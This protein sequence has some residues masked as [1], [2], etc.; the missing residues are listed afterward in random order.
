M[1]TMKAAAQAFDATCARWRD[2]YQAALRQADLQNQ[3]IRDA[4]RSAGDKRQAER[5]RREAEAQLKLLT[6]VD[7]FAQSD[8]YSYRYF[9]TEGFLPGYSFPRLPISAFIPGRRNRQRDEFL[10]RPRFLAVTEFGPRAII[11]H[12]GS[13]YLINQII[14]PVSMSEEDEPLTTQVKQC[15]HCGYLHPVGNGRDYDV[16]ERCG[17]PLEAPLEALLRLQNVVTQ[18]RDRINSDEE[19]RQR[20]GYDIRTGVRFTEKEGHALVQSAVVRAVYQD[21]PLALLTYAPTATLWRINLGW[22][23][24]K[25]KNRHGFVL[26]IERGYW[27]RNEQVEDDPVDPLSER[28]KLV[29]PF[30]EDSRNCL[31]FEPLIPLSIEQMTSLQAALKRAIEVRYQLEDNELAVEPL[32]DSFNRRLL[33]FYEAAEGGAGVLRRLVDE[34]EALACDR[35]GC[36]GSLPF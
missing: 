19:E 12:E 32:P 3:I 26:D 28:T 20:L 15:G 22:A 21:T 11:Y 17:M 4:S 25:N 13:R 18:R 36:P 5:L 2:L 33:L 35:P 10:S 29:I 7:S 9:A 24:R 27:A 16:C 14:M 23:R 6:E 31:L 1:L 34:P 8:F 30:V